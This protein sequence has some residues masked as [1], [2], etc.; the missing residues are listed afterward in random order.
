MLRAANT[1]RLL[2]VFAT[3]VPSRVFCEPSG[4]NA[5]QRPPSPP[6][7]PMSLPAAT[8]QQRSWVAEQ[9]VLG[10]M[11]T[12]TISR[13]TAEQGFHMPLRTA[14]RDAARLRDR[15]A[16]RSRSRGER[17]TAFGLRQ[18]KDVPLSPEV[19]R[20]AAEL[21]WEPA[22]GPRPYMADNDFEVVVKQSSLQADHGYGRGRKQLLGA[23]ARFIAGQ[24]GIEASVVPT[25]TWLRGMFEK[26]KARG[27]EVQP[28]KAKDISLKRVAAKSAH[29]PKLFFDKVTPVFE[30]E[31]ARG[32]QRYP[33]PEPQFK[34]GG[35]EIGI[36]H[37]GTWPVVITVKERDEKGRVVPKEVLRV[38]T[39]EHNNFWCS[40]FIVTRADGTAPIPPVVIHQAK[41]RTVAHLHAIPSDW[42]DVYFEASNS[43]T[44]SLMSSTPSTSTSAAASNVSIASAKPKQAAAGVV[45]TAKVNNQKPKANNA[46]KQP[47]KPAAKKQKTNKPPPAAAAPAAAASQKPEVEK[48]EA[49]KQSTQQ[50]WQTSTP[51]TRRAAARANQAFNTYASQEDDKQE[52]GIVPWRIYQREGDAVFVPSRCPH[53]VRNLRPCVKIAVDFVSVENAQFA[54]DLADDYRGLKQGHAHKEDVLQA[55]AV[56]MHAWA[57]AEA[58]ATGGA[59]AR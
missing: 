38:S 4:T 56:A 23:C 35:D 42:L 2:S 50:T 3:A 31:Y 22:K 14:E 49:Q 58:L 32:R 47:D 12:K 18:P 13:L 5:A 24:R 34:L 25:A 8:P 33:Q 27:V 15:V 39:G 17:L 11:N 37:K 41:E 44:N 10:R 51:P 40:M 20:A 16:N 9:F 1:L 6:G 46:D 48:E 36:S 57:A 59:G 26:A 53:Q 54:V 45:A 30:Q 28:I 43:L 52:T 29:L 21:G 19:R 55:R 7:P